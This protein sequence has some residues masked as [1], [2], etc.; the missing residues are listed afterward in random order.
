MP[1]NCLSFAVEVSGEVD[2]IGL[3]GELLQFTDDF[4]LA[5]QNLVMGFPFVLR[6]DTHSTHQLL[7][8][9]LLAV[10][11]LFFRRHLAGARRLGRSLLRIRRAGPSARGG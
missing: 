9:L 7:P 10:L 11:G 3:G 2:R 4:F 8:R 1:G 6:V 5:G